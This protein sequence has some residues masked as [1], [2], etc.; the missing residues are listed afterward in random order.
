[1]HL[2]S[3]CARVDL[4]LAFMECVCASGSLACIYAVSVRVWISRV[5]LCSECARL[6]LSRAFM[7]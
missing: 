7:Q 6:D 2:W 4:S 3:V 1:M 5:H